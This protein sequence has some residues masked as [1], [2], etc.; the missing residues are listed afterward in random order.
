[1]R[2]PPIASVIMSC[3]AGPFVVG[4][5]DQFFGVLAGWCARPDT[6]DALRPRRA[7]EDVDTIFTT[8]LP[9]LGPAPD[10]HA[11]APCGSFRHDLPRQRRHSRCVEKLCID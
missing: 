6:P 4:H 7:D 1:M 8:L 3:I 5:A 9:R 2:V 11:S 10:N